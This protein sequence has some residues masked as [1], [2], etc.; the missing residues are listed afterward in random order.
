MIMLDVVTKCIKGH[1][2]NK[3]SFEILKDSVWTQLSYAPH[4]S[5]TPVRIPQC[6]V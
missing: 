1:D 4:F 2:H 5:R 6:R 3:E